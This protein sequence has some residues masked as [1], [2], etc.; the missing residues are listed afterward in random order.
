MSSGRGVMTRSRVPSHPY[1]S[2]CRLHYFI[3]GQT[4]LAI[5]G[6]A[7]GAKTSRESFSF[8]GLAPNSR[9]IIVGSR[10]VEGGIC[11][12]AKQLQHFSLLNRCR[13]YQTMI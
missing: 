5:F 11:S 8:H 10:A 7:T 12:F 9:C 3:S 4:Y 6:L 1:F 2:P 13:G